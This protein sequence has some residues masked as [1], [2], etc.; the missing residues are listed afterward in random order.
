MRSLV[1]VFLIV[2][3]ICNETR[4]NTLST[5]DQFENIE[6]HDAIA[7]N[8]SEGSTQERLKWWREFLVPRN[9]NSKQGDLARK[10]GAELDKRKSRF[11]GSLAFL[12]GLSVGGLAGAASSTMKS[13]SKVPAPPLALNLAASRFSPYITAFYDPFVAQ[14]YLY[15]NPFALYPFIEPSRLQ[16]SLQNGLGQQN[17]P[18]SQLLALYGVKGPA[19]SADNED[20]SAAEEGEEKEKRNEKI[21]DG[22]YEEAEIRSESLVEAERNAEEKMVIRAVTCGTPK[23]APNKQNNLPNSLTSL[24]F[25]QG[26]MNP[27]A[28]N[29]FQNNNQ[30]TT[31]NPGAANAMDNS[32]VPNNRTEYPPFIG[33]YGGHPQNVG[34]LDLTT[35]TN[36]FG[37]P[38]FGQNNYNLPHERPANFYQ[39]DKY[40]FYDNPANLY[41]SGQFL[42]EQEYVSSDFNRVLYS[43]DNPS[44]SEGF[45]P[46][47]SVAVRAESQCVDFIG[48]KF[49]GGTRCDRWP[50]ALTDARE[51]ARKA[52]AVPRCS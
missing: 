16:Q 7:A 3:V 12:A 36:V 4:C 38:D 42:P 27:N 17:H 52:G 9:K 6:E 2:G 46:V 11:I 28:T 5:T 45:R 22:A 24:S 48:I 44:L 50:T 49:D 21:S 10:P 34:H 29:N 40:D 20:A 13:Y 8:K 41:P 1:L 31:I 15:P 35:K 14:P 30:S 19:E 51:E 32:T 47:F 37:Y 43:R 25:R 18:L 33:Y 39:D 26:T 23:D